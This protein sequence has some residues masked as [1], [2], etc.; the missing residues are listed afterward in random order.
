M[1]YAA[2]S[3]LK[4]C[5]LEL[6]GKSPVIVAK[7]ADLE[8]A[9]VIACIAIFTNNGEVCTAGSRT[10]VHESIHDEFVKKSV[11]FMK[12]FTVGDPMK[13]N[14]GPVLYLSL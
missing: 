1:K 2:E 14:V 8:T 5:Q 3:N 7:D 4:K 11:A 13:S 10:F 12:S 9:V 6:G